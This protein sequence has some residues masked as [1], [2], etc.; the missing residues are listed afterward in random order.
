MT[1]VCFGRERKCAHI[2]N[3]PANEIQQFQWAMLHWPA[4]YGTAWH[5]ASFS[6]QLICENI[7]RC[8]FFASFF[9][10]LFG[11]WREKNR[12]RLAFIWTLKMTAIS[13][14]F[15][16][17]VIAFSRQST[18]SSRTGKWTF[19]RNIHFRTMQSY[20]WLKCYTF[21]CAPRSSER[22]LIW[23]YFI[24]FHLISSL[25]CAKKKTIY[26]LFI[27]AKL[28]IFVKQR[29]WFYTKIKISADE[30]PTKWVNAY[31]HNNSMKFRFECQ[32]INELCS[33]MPNIKRA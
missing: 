11:C 21:W 23:F 2:Q 30:Q 13:F 14:T 8:F 1:S 27:S 17:N 12:P 10:L 26:G 9:L 7:F 15:S 31:T 28:C 25:F 6:T 5:I 24:S 3:S 29:Q 19:D 33:T 4:R 16:V 20:I 18:H 32:Y 22:D